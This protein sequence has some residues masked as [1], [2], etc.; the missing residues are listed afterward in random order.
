MRITIRHRGDFSRAKKYLSKAIDAVTM[1][2]LSR[3]GEEGVL[4]LMSAT[5]VDSGETALS[6]RYEIEKTNTGYAISFHN[7][8]VVNDWFNV[9]LMLD[10]GHGTGT[11]GWVEG[12]NYIEPAL[13][14]VFDKMAHDAWLEVINL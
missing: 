9:A 13:R 3:Y 5:P 14:P 2:H 8:N 11:G 6:W 12:R 10:V 1:E 4:A 7:D